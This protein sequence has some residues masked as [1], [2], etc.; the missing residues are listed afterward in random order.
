MQFKKL[1]QLLVVGG[2]VVATNSACSTRAEA[3]TP[4]KA[5][6]DGGT[7]MPDAGAKAGGVKGW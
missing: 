4:K 7:M 3:Q 5:M 2:A 1:F 6:K